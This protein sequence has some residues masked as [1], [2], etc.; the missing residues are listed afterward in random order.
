MVRTSSELV[1]DRY[2]QAGPH[3][4][5]RTDDTVSRVI[6]FRP[7]GDMVDMDAGDSAGG[8]GRNKC[9]SNGRTRCCRSSV[10]QADVVLVFMGAATTT[11]VCLECMVVALCVL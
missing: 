3:R 10:L 6:I 7:T 9:A 11:L 5:D 4:T 1:L 8:G 2:V